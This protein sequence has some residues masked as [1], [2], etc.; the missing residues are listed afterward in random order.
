VQEDPRV[1]ERLGQPISDVSWVP[2]G[3]LNVEG[4]KGQA[5]LDFDVAGPKGRAHVHYQARQLAGKWGF[6]QLEVTFAPGDRISL[7]V[8]AGDEAPP[9]EGPKPDATK[10]EGNAPA[11]EINLL[12]P[13][14]DAPG[15]K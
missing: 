11:P 14:D 15:V 1:I 6:S 5:R 9:F 4:D 10:P 12:T 8:D 3:E 7:R 13:P 2:I